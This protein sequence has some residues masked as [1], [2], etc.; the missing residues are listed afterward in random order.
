MGG[1]RR[2]PEIAE[3]S[4]EVFEEEEFLHGWQKFVGDTL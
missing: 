3:L 2:K 1:T 4:K